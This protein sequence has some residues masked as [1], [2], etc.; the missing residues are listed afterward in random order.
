MRARYKF[1]PGNCAIT[2]LVVCILLF[3]AIIPG[4]GGG[5]V[6]PQPTPPE[7]S[8][9]PE[10][11]MPDLSAAM[12]VEAIGD[13]D[14]MGVILDRDTFDLLMTMDNPL[15]SDQW[16]TIYGSYTGQV[17]REGQSIWDQV[18]EMQ[19]CHGRE[20]LV[21]INFTISNTPNPPDHDEFDEGGNYAMHHS[22]GMCH[23][24]SVCAPKADVGVNCFSGPWG[25]TE[26]MSG[27][28]VIYYRIVSTTADGEPAGE[29]DDLKIDPK[30]WV[31]DFYV[32]EMYAD[33]WVG[34]TCFPIGTNMSKGYAVD[35]AKADLNGKTT[36]FT[37]SGS[38]KSG[39]GISNTIQIGVGGEFSEEGGKV[40][41]SFTAS[42]TR[43]KNSGKAVDQIVGRGNASDLD[44]PVYGWS[45]IN[46]A[47]KV[48]A[49]RDARAGAI[50]HLET[51]SAGIGMVVEIGGGSLKAPCWALSGCDAEQKASDYNALRDWFASQGFPDTPPQ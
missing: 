29:T 18:V 11:E 32:S 19:C 44:A 10:T 43:V 42:E 34:S 49:D 17:A 5:E 51:R 46:S 33:T 21:A 23:L 25:K 37:K 12:S 13:A 35:Y 1:F 9:L 48:Y 24:S 38:C 39:D 36:L 47:G 45:Y 15:T 28:T 50:S 20:Y 4:C 14:T 6:G 26:T 31:N 3:I 22:D 2:C 16:D 30:V 7:D 8:F 40:S 41:V 27:T